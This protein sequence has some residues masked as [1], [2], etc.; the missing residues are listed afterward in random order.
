MLTSL[1]LEAD[2]A[3]QHL[4]KLEEKYLE[5]ERKETR[6]ESWRTEDAEIILVGYGI[7]GRILK[8]VVELGRA[9]G[10]ALGMLRPI[11][12][13]PFPTRRIRELSRRAKAFVVV[14]L[15]TGQMV[16][17]VRLALEGRTPVEFFSRMGGNVPSAED[18]LEFLESKFAAREEEVLVH[19]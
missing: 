18:L 10:M 7:V 11:T 14:E 16:N 3:E 8:A 17:D 12:V 5:A 4:R 15:S 1:Y 19:G 9:R 2:L 6:F 13:F